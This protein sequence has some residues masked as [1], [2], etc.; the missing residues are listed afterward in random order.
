MT[1]A[2]EA[3]KRN[4]KCFVELS[5][6]AIY[7]PDPTPSKESAKLKPWL[8]L[9]KYKLQAES[10][11]QKIPGL[12]HCY[13]YFH[14]TNTTLRLNL[15]II[16]MANVY[17]EYC[18]KLVGTMLCMARAYKELGREMKWLWTKD[19]KCNTVHVKD[20]ARA[21]W[22][23]AQWYVN[24]KTNWDEGAMGQTPI[25]NIVDQGDTSQL[26]LAPC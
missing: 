11:L 3:A 26:S 17:G 20:V 21:L 15:V 8:K 1:A 6:G 12:V 4:V 18:S 19:L 5:H 23:V 13:P 7:K 22:H 25:F 2:K 14:I 24:G 16:R 9:A 10:E